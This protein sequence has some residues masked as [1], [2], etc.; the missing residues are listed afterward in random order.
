M[1]IFMHPL[2]NHKRNIYKYVTFMGFSLSDI[3]IQTRTQHSIAL[4]CSPHSAQHTHTHTPINSFNTSA[5]YF[6]LNY[7]CISTVV[8]L[9]AMKC[10]KSK[11]S[12]TTT[13]K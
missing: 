13:T 11:G 8:I 5:N 10:V 6:L 9:N 12:N 4:N 2:E 7:G 3:F 1:Y